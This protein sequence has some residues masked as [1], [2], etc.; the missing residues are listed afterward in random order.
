MFGVK[1]GAIDSAEGAYW[2]SSQSAAGSEG[3]LIDLRAK[4]PEDVRKRHAIRAIL[5]VLHRDSSNIEV[6]SVSESDINLLAAAKQLHAETY[7]RLGY[8]QE[9]DLADDGLRIGDDAD[10]YQTRSKYFV[11]RECGPSDPEV[12]A[13]ARMTFTEPK[14]GLRSL[15]IMKE[16]PLFENTSNAIKNLDPSRC[17]EFSAL[18]KRDKADPMST[19]M[20]Y[21]AI[22]RH[23]FSN[24]YTT[25]FMT[26]DPK[27]LARLMI[28][29]GAGMEPIGETTFYEGGYVVP[30]RLDVAKLY[31]WM[32]VV[33]DTD[34]QLELELHAAVTVHLMGAAFYAALNKDR[35]LDLTKL[36][37]NESLDNR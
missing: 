7:L 20:L 6:T 25:W 10:P 32:A 16:L 30:A 3:R 22:W 11:A 14:A 15:Q 18:V 8:V 4:S 9:I 36:E 37:G 29:F 23:A 17:F 31:N 13:T 26:C 33:P 21:R 35:Y 5:K 34:N 28:M 12:A 1:L 2:S 19:M 27:L 24:G